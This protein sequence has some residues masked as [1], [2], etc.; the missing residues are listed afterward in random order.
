MGSGLIFLP[1]N[2]E[3]GINYKDNTYPFRQDSS[4]LYYAGIDRAGLSLVIDCTTGESIL[5]AD[6][7]TVDDIVWTGPMPSLIQLAEHTGIDRI[8]S[9]EKGIEFFH[10]AINKKIPVHYLPIYRGDQAF[11]ISDYLHTTPQSIDN[12]YSETLAK[13]VVNQREIKS[14]EELKELEVAINY[15]GEMHY[16]LMTHAKIGMTEAQLM[17]KVRTTCLAHNVDIPYAIILSVNGQTLHN[18]SYDNTLR[19]GQLVLGDFGAESPMHYAGDITRTVPVDKKF[20]PLQKDIYNLVLNTLQTSIDSVKNGVAYK[21]IHLKAAK[22]IASGM[23]DLGFLNGDPEE[24]VGSGAHALFFPHGLG[25]PLGLDVHDMEGI[26]EQYTGYEPGMERSKE[27]GLKSL[28]LAKTLKT[29]MVLTVE[30]GIYFIPELISIWKAQNKFSDFINY[31]A[32]E[33]VLPFGGIRIE[34]NVSVRDHDSII[35]GNPIP[36]SVTEI[37]ELRI[38]AYQ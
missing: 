24:I 2:E 27:F 29:G 4:F 10:A 18:H 3:S 36:K 22:T 33:K 13:A 32:I 38:Y 35:L 8:I 6:E 12:G 30:P 28:R 5:I 23:K 1:G 15:S 16:T 14:K 9:V 37:E 21:S 11:K 7:L 20:T 31:A 26:G 25:H 17:A 19:S 34:D